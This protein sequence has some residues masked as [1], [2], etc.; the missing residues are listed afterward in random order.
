MSGKG[1]TL[2]KDNLQSHYMNIGALNSDVELCLSLTVKLAQVQM[3]ESKEEAGEGIPGV[4][5]EPSRRIKAY[6]PQ[7]C[8]NEHPPINS[9]M[10]SL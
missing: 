10:P 3:A 2:H 1:E 8:V 9:F 4:A 6:S 5:G 7:F